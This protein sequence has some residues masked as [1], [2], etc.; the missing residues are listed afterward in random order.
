MVKSEQV[1]ITV[2][3]RKGKAV[4]GR[5]EVTAGKHVQEQGAS[6]LLFQKQMNKAKQARE[7]SVGRANAAQG[8]GFS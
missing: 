5:S 7:T 1:K 4:S 6:H 2:Y 3:F 8:S